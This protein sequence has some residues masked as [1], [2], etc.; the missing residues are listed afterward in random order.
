MDVQ[1]RPVALSVKIT[2]YFITNHHFT[3][4]QDIISLENGSNKNTIKSKNLFGVKS[5]L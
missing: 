4:I 3:Y 1:S 2:S 5:I